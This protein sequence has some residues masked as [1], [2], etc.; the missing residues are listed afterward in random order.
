M[1]QPTDKRQRILEGALLQFVKKG[2]HGAAV[3]DIAAAAGVAVGT[4]YRYF[5]SKEALANALIAEWRRRFETDV[6][7]PF[8]P[9]ATPRAAFRL[10][11]RRMAAFAKTFPDAHRFLELH[12]HGSYLD[13]GGSDGDHAILDATRDLI[14]WGRREGAMKALDPALVLALLRGALAGLTRHAAVD[15]RVPAERIEDMEDCLWNA[16]A[17]RS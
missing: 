8:P 14:A 1:K 6:L 15:A 2:F 5:E 9:T 12:E 10:Y 11:W 4:I 17:S 3:P 13:A 7:A 16:V